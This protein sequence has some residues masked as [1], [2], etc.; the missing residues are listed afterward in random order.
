MNDSAF[1]HELLKCIRDAQNDANFW[2]RGGDNP[3]NELENRLERQF[4]GLNRRLEQSAVIVDS[5][6]L[7]PERVADDRWRHLA[8]QLSGGAVWALGQ[9]VVKKRFV[10]PGSAPGT[11]IASQYLSRAFP[12]RMPVR[13]LKT[14]VLGRAIGRA[15]PAVGGHD[16]RHR[17]HRNTACEECR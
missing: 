7:K 17:R 8:A 14:V 16:H 2:L 15:F 9:P 10:M 6:S 13:I 5:V 4:E 3:E 1:Q 11:S 12:Q